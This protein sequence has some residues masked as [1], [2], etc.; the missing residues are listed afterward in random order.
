MANTCILMGRE[1]IWRFCIL[2]KRASMVT[3]RKEKKNIYIYIHMYIRSVSIFTQYSARYVEVERNMYGKKQ[4]VYTFIP[5][6]MFRDYSPI[7]VFFPDYF[8]PDEGVITKVYP[9]FF[10]TSIYIY[11]Q[12]YTYIHIT[13]YIT[14]A[15]MF[16]VT[17]DPRRQ[18]ATSKS[19][20][21]SHLI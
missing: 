1:A 7:R 10:P 5:T 9:L 15:L 16:K 21:P 2:H 6:S 11:R 4:R 8:S 20:P 13:I 18:W 17:K 19:Q 12:I 3:L 14:L